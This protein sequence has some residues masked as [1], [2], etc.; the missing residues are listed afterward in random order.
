MGL[1]LRVQEFT[2]ARCV[3]TQTSAVLSY[4][5]TEAW[6]HAVCFFVKMVRMMVGKD[7]SQPFSIRRISFAPWLGQTAVAVCIVQTELARHTVGMQVVG[8]MGGGG[9]RLLTELS[10]RVIEF[11]HRPSHSHRNMSHQ[12][13]E[14]W[15]GIPMRLFVFCGL[16]L[17]SQR[18]RRSFAELKLRYKPKETACTPGCCTGLGDGITL[19]KCNLEDQRPHLVLNEELGLGMPNYIKHGSFFV[20][21]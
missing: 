1:I 15:E 13:G 11:R 19:V 3:I 5:A 9:R 7:F 17:L 8:R 2:T 10:N 12:T 16:R 14:G 21:P 4:F 6:N 20:R 18:Q